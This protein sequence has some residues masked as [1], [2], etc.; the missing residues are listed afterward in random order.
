MG[1]KVFLKLFCLDIPKLRDTVGVAD[2]IEVP[3]LS[4]P[5]HDVNGRNVFE[6]H[7]SHAPPSTPQPRRIGSSR[8][9]MRYLP[10]TLITSHLGCWNDTFELQFNHLLIEDPSI[11]VFSTEQRAPIPRRWRRDAEHRTCLFPFR[12]LSCNAKVVVGSGWQYEVSEKVI[13]YWDPNVGVMLVDW[14]MLYN[15]Y[16]ARKKKTKNKKKVGEIVG[17]HRELKE[18]TLRTV[19]GGVRRSYGD[20]NIH[21][22]T[23]AEVASIC[24]YEG[25]GFEN[26]LKPTRKMLSVQKLKIRIGSFVNVMKEALRKRLERRGQSWDSG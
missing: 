5:T 2:T 20:W 4:E 13:R 10:H 11:A 22:A 19:T 17:R 25:R 24:K 23:C 14:H 15:S 12:R 26:G 8:H 7:H 16:F 6:A 9:P 3:Q 18:T 1:S 21:P